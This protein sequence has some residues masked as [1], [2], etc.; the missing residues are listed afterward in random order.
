[1]ASAWAGRMGSYDPHDTELLRRVGT[2]RFR[3]PS[4]CFLASQDRLAPPSIQRALAAHFE[5]IRIVEVPTWHLHCAE[6][7]GPAYAM[8]IAASVHGWYSGQKQGGH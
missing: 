3:T 6:V 5:T 1:M 7:L 2:L 4:L 8:D